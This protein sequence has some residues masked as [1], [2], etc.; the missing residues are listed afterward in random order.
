MSPIRIPSD[1]ALVNLYW[2]G[3]ADEWTPSGSIKE[4]LA[5]D[6]TD[7]HGRTRRWPCCTSARAGPA[8]AEAPLKAIVAKAPDSSERFILADYYVLTNRTADA[9]ALLDD[10]AKSPKI[11]LATAAKLR[12]AALGFIDGRSRDHVSAD[13]G[14]PE[15][16]LR[17]RPR[18]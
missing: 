16:R 7:I 4:A 2:V 9:K 12:L 5:I 10:I 6:P 17:A 3:R 18:P 1:L 14:D 15:A 13:R 8:D 11:E